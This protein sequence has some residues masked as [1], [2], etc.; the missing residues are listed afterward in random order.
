MLRETLELLTNEVRV[1]GE[2]M[3]LQNA[4]LDACRQQIERQVEELHLTRQELALRDRLLGEC[5]QLLDQAR[6]QLSRR[7]VKGRLRALLAWLR[8][9]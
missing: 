3:K 4:Q 7:G 6:H 1:Q 2:L 8:G 9:R 5:R